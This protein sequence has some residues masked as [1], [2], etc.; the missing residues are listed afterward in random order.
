MALGVTSPLL[1]VRKVMEE[2]SFG[3]KQCEG[4]EPKELKEIIL[5][6]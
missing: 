4:I 1:P 3:E 6:F 5:H 2:I